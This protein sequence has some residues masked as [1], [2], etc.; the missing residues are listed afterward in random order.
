MNHLTAARHLAHEHALIRFETNGT[1]QFFA[2]ALRARIIDSECRVVLT[3]DEGLRAKKV[4]KLK[5]T[6]D[7][8]LN[9]PDCSCVEAVLVHRRTGGEVGWVDG[10][11]QWMHEAMA[12]ERPFA[13]AEPMGGE[14]PLFLLYTSGSTGKPKG[15]VHAHGG[16]LAGLVATSALVF[17]LQ[18]ARND[19]LFVVATPGWIT[20]QSYMIAAALLCRVPSVL[21]EGS[22]VSPPDR[23]AVAMLP[24]EGVLA[25]GDVG[26]A[27][28]RRRF[29]YREADVARVPLLRDA[30]PMYAVQ[31]AG[32]ACFEK[33]EVSG[34]IGASLA[35]G[36]LGGD[37]TNIVKPRG[38][39]A[40]AAFA[41]GCV[42]V[43]AFARW[44][45]CAAAGAGTGADVVVGAISDASDAI[46]LRSSDS[47]SAAAP[48]PPEA[49]ILAR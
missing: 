31:F 6:V 34:D 8:A 17:D 41:A 20:G 36:G 38:R 3:A 11:D 47:F 30:L 25:L 39:Q 24:N 18:P 4:I 26:L 29:A 48:A 12:R 10:R 22:P 9:S 42:L 44:A 46:V 49:G 21:L 43:L 14:D 37:W 32:G 40:L 7:S 28:L 1:A 13:A 23:F 45:A 15:I 2:E 19:V 33:F 35:A 5:Q 27:A 16:Y